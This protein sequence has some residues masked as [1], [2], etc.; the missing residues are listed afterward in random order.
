MTRLNYAI[1]KLYYC[2]SNLDPNIKN[3]IRYL[4]NDPIQIINK[5]FDNDKRVKFMGYA[6][7]CYRCSL[8]N[9]GTSLIAPEVCKICLQPFNSIKKYSSK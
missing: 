6:T 5:D 8:Q 4:S 3:K 9:T 7:E 2:M 1:I